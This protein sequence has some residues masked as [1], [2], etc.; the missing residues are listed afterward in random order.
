MGSI[1]DAPDGD[2][3]ATLLGSAGDRVDGSLGKVDGAAEQRLRRARVG[4]DDRQLE[5]DLL[6]PPKAAVAHRD[7]RPLERDEGRQGDLEGER[8]DLGHGRPR[9]AHAR[10]R[11]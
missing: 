5:V 10:S 3:V 9:R 11:R 1:D 6:L 8:R 2:E 7:E 4:V